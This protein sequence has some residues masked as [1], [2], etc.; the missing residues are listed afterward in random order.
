MRITAA[1]A[2]AALS[3]AAFAPPAAAFCGF[4][5]GKADASL[6]NEASQVMMVRDGG[7]TTITMLNDYKGALTEFALVVPVPVVLKREDIRVADKKVF[8]RIL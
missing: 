1:A 6:F 8:E 4:F 2:L 3:A 7:K 5:V